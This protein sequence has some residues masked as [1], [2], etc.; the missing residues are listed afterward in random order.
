MHPTFGRPSTRFAVGRDL[1][2]ARH[3]LGASNAFLFLVIH[4]PSTPATA[5]HFS[6]KHSFLIGKKLLAK[7][8]LH[9]SQT[10]NERAGVKGEG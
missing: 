5:K 9:L 7:E 4:N 10:Q 1:N 8:V 6:E 3:P 2:R